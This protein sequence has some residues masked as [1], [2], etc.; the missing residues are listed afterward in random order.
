MAY[1][2]GVMA[3]YFTPGFAK[4]VIVPIRVLN[5]ELYAV[6]WSGTKLVFHRRGT[7]SQ[8]QPDVLNPGS[9]K[10]RHSTLSLRRP[11]GERDDEALRLSEHE[12]EPVAPE[13]TEHRGSPENRS[14][15][16]TTSSR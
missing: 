9:P 2:V 13:G 7:L 4:S 11:G 1:G 12:V 16:I 5:P 10:N 15:P 8:F 3:Y 6:I 14:Y